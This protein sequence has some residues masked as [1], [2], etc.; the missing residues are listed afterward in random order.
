MKLS[1]LSRDEV[2]FICRY[3]RKIKD[4]GE[5]QSFFD[6]TAVRLLGADATDLLQICNDAWGLFGPQPFT[7]RKRT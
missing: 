5:R 6:Y 1:N 4:D 3:A 7:V 2:G